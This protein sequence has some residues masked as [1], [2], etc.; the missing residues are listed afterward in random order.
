MRYWGRAVNF[1][2]WFAFSVLIGVLPFLFGFVIAFLNSA[3]SFDAGQVLG[4]GELLAVC[5]AI[6]GA[7]VGDLLS[8]T[9]PILSTKPGADRV[10]KTFIAFGCILVVIGACVG[11]L[12]VPEHP[13]PV[14]TNNMIHY[15][16]AIF[17]LTLIAGTLSKWRE[18]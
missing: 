15:S 5:L 10:L 8:S 13:K 16:I 12:A 2:L 14:D 6:A 7:V 1:L 4:K 3:Y 9:Q 17:V 18:R 11:I